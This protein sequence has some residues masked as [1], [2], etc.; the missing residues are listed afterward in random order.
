MQEVRDGVGVIHHA[1]E[2]LSACHRKMALSIC[3][4]V[5]SPNNNNGYLLN[6]YS[7]AG[8]VLSMLYTLSH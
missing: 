7:E 8:F 2:K 5:G 4:R 6:M 1:L 3:D